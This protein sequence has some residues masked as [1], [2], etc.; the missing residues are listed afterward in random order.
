[1]SS[2]ITRF[3]ILGSGKIATD[4]CTALSYLAGDVKA[5]AVAARALDSAKDFASKFDIPRAYGSYEEL[6]KDPEVDVIYISVLHPW[7]YNTALMCLQNGKGI[8]C[9]KPLT[10]NAKQLEHLISVA[11]ER[12]LFFM[13]AMWTRYFPYSMR[14]RELI[15]E[16]IIGD[17]KLFQV[18]FCLPPID[19]ATHRVNDPKLGGGALLD[20]GI[21]TIAFSQ[22]VFEGRVPVKTNVQSQMNSLGADVFD[23]IVL[24]YD[25]GEKSI[26]TLSMV[27]PSENHAI[28]SGTRGYIKVDAPFNCSTGF[29]AHVI[30]EDGTN[31]TQ[32]YDYPLPPVIPGTSFYF[33]NGVGMV[34]E[35]RYV[36]KLIQSGKIESDQETL[37][38]SLDIMKILDEL[39]RQMGLVYEADSQ[40]LLH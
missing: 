9:E 3:G 17:V 25:Q 8:L 28:I 33:P 7:H 29:T 5:V 13:E 31:T 26:H 12:K 24:E 6:T 23:H 34:H 15:K 10:M 21:Y 16:G 37:E 20:I 14:L 2:N 18:N 32:R 35:A 39:R 4:F 36:H 38:E 22:M 11:R 30:T 27:S 1:M 40:P 19:D